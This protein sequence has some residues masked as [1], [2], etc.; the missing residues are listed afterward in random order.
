MQI[1]D[2]KS[3]GIDSAK[4]FMNFLVFGITAVLITVF[5]SRTFEL[6]AINNTILRFLIKALS[7]A[8]VF[9][10]TAFVLDKETKASVLSIF[11][12]I[13]KRNKKQVAKY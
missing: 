10:I 1:Y 7:F 6:I 9:S 11:K 2:Q 3:T 13:F 4:F 12:R 5:V 8:I